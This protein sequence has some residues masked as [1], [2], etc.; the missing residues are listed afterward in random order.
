MNFV[1]PQVP[2]SP[3][4]TSYRVSRTEIISLCAENTD[5]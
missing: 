5:D 3:S 1:R 4:H 2:Y